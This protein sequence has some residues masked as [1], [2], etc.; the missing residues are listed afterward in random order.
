MVEERR[1][2]SVNEMWEELMR[3][4]A[5]VQGVESS[6]EFLME[7]KKLLLDELRELKRNFEFLSEASKLVELKR[8]SMRLEEIG[9]AMQRE[10]ECEAAAVA[11]EVKVVEALHRFA[12]DY[13]GLSVEGRKRV[14]NVFCA[15]LWRDGL[16][17][18]ADN[19]EK[20]LGVD[21][22]KP[23][24]EVSKKRKSSQE[25]FDELKKNSGVL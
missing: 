5:V 18:L 17:D 15:K 16:P 9:K 22:E 12:P 7:Q 4:A 11:E 1:M 10:V 25:I 8:D 13:D 23:T 3:Q 14:F 6:D 24:D 20:G 19:I 21:E 2:K